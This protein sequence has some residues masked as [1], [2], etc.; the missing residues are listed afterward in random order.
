LI[1][2]LI[3]TVLAIVVARL[4]GK[5]SIRSNE[6]LEEML[7]YTPT[8]FPLLFAALMGRFFRHLGIWLAERGTTLGRLEQLVG[9]QSVF[10][11]IERQICLRN[12]SIVGLCSILVWLLSPFGGQSA[13]R[14][15]RHQ[16]IFLNSTKTLHYV[17]PQNIR[18]SYMTGA[19]SINSG[20]STFASL[21]LAALLSSANFQATPMDLWNNVKLPSYRA[22]ENATSDEWKPVPEYTNNTIRWSSL[23]GIPVSAFDGEDFTT[24][25]MNH[26][27][28][29]AR[30]FDI[31][32]FNN[33]Q[34]TK[35]QSGFGNLT[36]SSTWKIASAVIQP[37][38][39]DP[40]GCKVKGC[41]S[42]P[43]PIVSRSLADKVGGEYTVSVANC[44]Y[45]YDYIEASIECIASTCK[46]TSMRKLDPYTDGYTK[47]Q[48]S[49]L[50]SIVMFNQMITMPRVDTF[51]V[52]DA[53]V[54][55]AS[56]MEK[57]LVDPTDFIGSS[58]YANVKMYELPVDVFAERL[59]ILW[60]S[61][62]QA[63]YATRALA[64]NL[65]KATSTNISSESIGSKLTFNATQSTVGQRLD[66]YHVNW[67]WFGVL[68]GCSLVLLVAAYAGLALKYMSL[69]PDIIGYA[70]SLTMLNPYMPTP[71]GGTT[72]HG[73]ERTALL[74]DLPV[75]IGDVC[76]NEPV[77]A[78]ALAANDGR[79]VG[80]DRRRWYI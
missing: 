52:A 19:S 45:S 54:R 41:D 40:E 11:A 42:Y 21:F 24:S 5:T 62:F 20:R 18:N 26:F 58:M 49:S 63:T 44:E 34:M 31:N 39:T 22:L 71:T 33:T 25:S 68:M 61:F 9:C 72:L 35:N 69:A 66:V 38:C 28:I 75:R 32:C 23:I 55:G 46:A 6:K 78:I 70:S 79:V 50:R 73:L 16:E 36:A 56:V 76:P 12:F 14:V 57:W 10:L 77:G 59:T 74:H 4:N 37:E 65:D 48:D 15:L 51:G 13:L 43:C 30:Q 80:L 3:E 1:T 53:A 17:D 29:K 27:N 60:N 47:D 64:G 8:V 7:L 2:I 67:R